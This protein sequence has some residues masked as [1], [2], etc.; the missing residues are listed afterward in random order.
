MQTQVRFDIGFGVPGELAFDGPRRAQA[1][2][3][4]S[5][6]ASSNVVGRWFTRNDDGTFA[7]GGT[8]AD[9][10]LL[11]NPKLYAA[12]GTQVGGTLAPTLTIPN[13]TVGEFLMEGEVIALIDGAAKEGDDVHYATATGALSAVAP[14][15]EPAAGKAAVPGA[16]VTRVQQT[17]ET[18]GLVVIWLGKGSTVYNITEA[19]G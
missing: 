2:I 8:G 9:G 11:A 17:S 5:A 12:F 16:R 3:V 1:G 13:G 19:A 15:T 18:G 10:G 14:G 6:D 4:D 7:A